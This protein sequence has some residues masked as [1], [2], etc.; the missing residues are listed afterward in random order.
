MSIDWN[1]TFVLEKVHF[2][3]ILFTYLYLLGI[4]DTYSRTE[5]A[6]V[7]PKW[8]GIRRCLLLLRLQMVGRGGVG[9]GGGGGGEG[10]FTF[11]EQ[12]QQQVAFLIFFS[13]CI[14]ECRL[15]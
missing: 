7:C 4:I 15:H 10:G 1:Q 3:G 9:L 11:L 12:V 8:R 2:V 5:V 6:Y 13:D 14:S